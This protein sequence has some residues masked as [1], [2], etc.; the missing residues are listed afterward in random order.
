MRSF[1]LSSLLN[2]SCLFVRNIPEIVHVRLY[3]FVSTARTFT[4]T[5]G[6]VAINS[7]ASQNNARTFTTT[8]GGVVIKSRAS[9][10]DARTF[11]ATLGSVVIKSRASQ[12]SLVREQPWLTRDIKHTPGARLSERKPLKINENIASNAAAQ[13]CR[14]TAT[15]KRKVD[16]AKI[17]LV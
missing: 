13:E 10:I 5:L 6:S 1:F 14:R 16:A 15:C 9:Q 2:D 17:S 12:K 8:L 11:T 3:S 4:T 7:R